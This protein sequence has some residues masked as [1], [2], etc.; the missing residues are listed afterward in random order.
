MYVCMHVCVYVCVHV[1]MY[2]CM[3]ACM[4]V[5]MY[6]CMYVCTY[7]CMYVCM[8][9]WQI[10]FKRFGARGRDRRWN[11]AVESNA[12]GRLS[13]H[14]GRLTAVVEDLAAC[15]GFVKGSIGFLKKSGF[16]PFLVNLVRTSARH[17]DFKN[18]RFA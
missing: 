15:P 7:V 18:E 13:C 4:H 17:K 9:I 5:C 10:A 1:C 3:H 6:V 16:V 8:H 2:V 14:D 12:F 11:W